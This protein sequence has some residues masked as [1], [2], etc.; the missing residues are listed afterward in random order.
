MMDAILVKLR[1][2]I[3]RLA[4]LG[5]TTMIVTADHG[6]LLGDELGEDMKLDAPGGETLDLH[7]RVWVGRGGA[8]GGAALLRA[9]LS[10]FWAHPCATVEIGL[11]SGGASL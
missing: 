5:C 10:A 8:A 1:G 7:R 4:E 6:F 9:A 11:A 2:A 3:R